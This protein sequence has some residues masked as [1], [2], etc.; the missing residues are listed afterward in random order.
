MEP[1]VQ[2]F[3]YQFMLGYVDSFDEMLIVSQRISERIA[4]G[5]QSKPEYD[6]GKRLL[7]LLNALD[8]PGLTDK[9]IEGLEYCLTALTEAVFMAGIVPVYEYTAPPAPTPP[10]DTVK[11]KVGS[12]TDEGD[13]IGSLTD[14]GDG[15][16]EI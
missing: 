4:A 2:L 8:S 3:D 16:S 13:S 11:F 10:V 9:Q 14:P 12:N 6:R 1:T 15:I 7:L 5:K